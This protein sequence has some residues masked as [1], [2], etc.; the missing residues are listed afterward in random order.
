MNTNTKKVN[1][2]LKTF[3]V[4]GVSF[5]PSDLIDAL[6][7]GESIRLTAE[8]DNKF[9]ANAIKIECLFTREVDDEDGHMV[10]KETWEHIGYIPKGDTWIFHLIR[11]LGGVIR[12][13]LDVNPGAEPHR[14]LLVT[15]AVEIDPTLGF[16]E[17]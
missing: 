4:A 16:K 8:P 12:L 14:M 7:V 9:D 3:Y 11:G 13:R 10:D 2:P 1:Q 5:R 17:D 15:S 6:G